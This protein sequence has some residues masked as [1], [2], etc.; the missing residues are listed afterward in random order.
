[1]VFINRHVSKEDKVTKL[2]RQNQTS[3]FSLGEDP[4]DGKKK[5]KQ[6]NLYFFYY[7]ELTSSSQQHEA[8]ELVDIESWFLRNDLL[9]KY[10]CEH[11][12]E[13]DKPHPR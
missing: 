4:D 13:N 10:E 8:H 12:D 6:T 5:K 3:V 7:L 1:M 11:F 9:Y 2:Y